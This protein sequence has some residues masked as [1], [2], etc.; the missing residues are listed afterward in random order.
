LTRLFVGCIVKIGLS[1][2]NISERKDTLKIRRPEMSKFR[3]GCFLALAVIVALT[4]IV[5][6]ITPTPTDTPSLP[7]TPNVV[8]FVP[9]A[10]IPPEPTPI[11]APAE[12]HTPKPASPQT[13]VIVETPTPLETPAPESAPVSTPPPVV[14]ETPAP[15]STPTPELTPTLTPPL[16]EKPTSPPE[17]TI[18]LLIPEPT[19]LPDS[20]G[21]GMNDWFEE[22]II[23]SSPEIPNE[24]YLT[25]IWAFEIKPHYMGFNCTNGVCE[26]YID[27][28]KEAYI[29]PFAPIRTIGSHWSEHRYILRENKFKPE[30]IIQLI[31]KEA[32]AENFEEAIR[33]ITRKATKNDLVYVQLNGHGVKGQFCFYDQRQSYEDIDEILDSIESKVVVVAIMA[34]HAAESIDP[35]I[36]GPCPRVVIAPTDMLLYSGLG[37]GLWKKVLAEKIDEMDLDKNGYLS[38]KEAWLAYTKGS[39][40]T[41]RRKSINRKLTDEIEEGWNYVFTKGDGGTL[42]CEI[43]HKDKGCWHDTFLD[44][45]NIGGE[46]YLGDASVEEL[47]D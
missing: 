19:P 41:M 15:V 35:L 6:A 2:S 3:I 25:W 37:G 1:Q 34:C 46:I 27:V 24:R 14:V 7:P 43:S 20:D 30:N 33:E 17:P 44:P 16:T 4:A 39:Y 32:T 12:I 9:P 26:E 47:K 11:E 31:G 21:D 28:N 36:E 23:H 45:D 5:F 10:E 22:N 40:E 42:F 13:S 8:I 38:I 18:A 29:A